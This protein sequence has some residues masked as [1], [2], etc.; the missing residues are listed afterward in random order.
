MLP[1]QYLLVALAA[2]AAGAINALAGGGTLI[3][4][5]MLIAVGIHSH[6]CEIDLT[7][8]VREKK[9]IIGAHDTT[10][11][12]FE[13]AIALLSRH[14]DA[15]GQM[16]THHMPLSRGAEAFAIARQGASVK[17]MLIPDNLTKDAD[18]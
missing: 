12:A 4:F 8:L 7:R 6:P 17:V 10:R 5:P 15:L 1:F 9:R 16:I 14:R 3:T 18:R 13:Q 11:R 2:F